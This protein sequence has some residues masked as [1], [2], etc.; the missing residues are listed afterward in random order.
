MPSITI[1][2]TTVKAAIPTLGNQL[3]LV[4]HKISVFFVLMRL[5]PIFLLPESRRQFNEM[6]RKCL[7]KVLDGSSSCGAENEEEQNDP[8]TKSLLQLLQ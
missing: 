3:Y 7:K 8:K 5:Q 4:R 1:G 2:T 6:K